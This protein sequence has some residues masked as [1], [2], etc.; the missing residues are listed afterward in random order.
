M[1]YLKFAQKYQKNKYLQML[2]ITKNKKGAA[3]QHPS[4]INKMEDRLLILRD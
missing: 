3:I 2:G 1:Y 4:A